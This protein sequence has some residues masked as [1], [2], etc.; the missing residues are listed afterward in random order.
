MLADH[1]NKHDRN[2]QVFLASIA[3]IAR[4]AL[5]VALSGGAASLPPEK[6]TS[7]LPISAMKRDGSQGISSRACLRFSQ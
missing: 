5:P 1:E 3:F 2:K 6:R 4:G 7:S